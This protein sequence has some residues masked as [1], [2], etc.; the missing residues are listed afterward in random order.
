LAGD[1]GS[2]TVWPIAAAVIRA[3]ECTPLKQKTFISLF[4]FW[5]LSLEDEKNKFGKNET[6]LA[7]KHP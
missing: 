1:V 3:D 5:L 2:E 4:F 7:F 6:F